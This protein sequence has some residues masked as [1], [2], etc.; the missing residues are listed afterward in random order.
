M[1]MSEALETVNIE[2][3]G[4]EITVSNDCCIH[5]PKTET[6]YSEKQDE[7]DDISSKTNHK[8]PNDN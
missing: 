2:H 4:E 6:M 5:Y 1:V 7:S 8:N 3:I